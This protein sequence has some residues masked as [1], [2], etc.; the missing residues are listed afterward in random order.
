MVVII[1]NKDYKA[2]SVSMQTID[3]SMSDKCEMD[4]EMY[5][6]KDKNG[7]WVIVVK[8]VVLADS[9]SA[10]DVTKAW[11]VFPD[12]NNPGKMFGVRC[13]TDYNEWG[14]TAHQIWVENAWGYASNYDELEG[15]SWREG[16]EFVELRENRDELYRSTS[17]YG[18]SKQTCA[19]KHV[20]KSGNW[21]DTIF[22]LG[23]EVRVQNG[24]K[25]T[26][27]GSD[28]HRA[29]GNDFYY[30]INDPAADFE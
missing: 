12:N 20:V 10:F 15:E 24:V 14:G 26:M 13:E 18:K 21:N 16:G 11:A 29:Y 3:R 4:M 30:T 5:T 25:L 23:D 7:E 17:D 28:Y 19:A 1:A 9:L 6:D 8:F 2:N 22:K 27:F